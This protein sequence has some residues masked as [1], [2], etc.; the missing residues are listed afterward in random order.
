[1][2]E[3]RFIVEPA[4]WTV[5]LPELRRVREA[6]FIDEQKVP[7]SEEWD[8]LDPRCHHVLA[9]DR[10]RRAI[11]TGRLTPDG[12]IGR[13]AVLPAWRGI[14]VGTAILRVLIEQAR[15][16]GL[17]AV[18]LH[19]QR[20]AIGFYEKFGFEAYGEEFSEAG[21]PH[22]RMRLW[23]ADS[24]A[25]PPLAARQQQASVRE[26]D[27]LLEARALALELLAATG[28][29]L[30]IYSRDLDPLLLDD[31]EL[32]EALR[33]IA[34]SG[35]GADIRILVQSLDRVLHEG[36][37]LLNLAQRLTSSIQLRIPC[38]EDRSYAAA[39]IINDRAGYLY[40]PLAGRYEGEGSL[41]HIGRHDELLSLFEQ[42]WQ[43]AEPSPELRTV[44]IG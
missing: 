32:L 6:V 29:R 42:H 25:P 14:G 28:R 33:Q 2:I 12:K 24:A 7:L 10:E 43:R 18:R 26:F 17:P 38:S 1:M 30:W 5:D 35:R 41:H 13:M 3:E 21:I 39:F 31:S 8:E 11:G 27:S 23:L 40:R 44:T 9:R 4:S 19:A 34:L 16:L 15:E 22:R 37:R 20:H 36:H